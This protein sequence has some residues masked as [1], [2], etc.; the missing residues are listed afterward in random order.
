MNLDHEAVDAQIATMLRDCP[1]GT[2]TDL[3]EFA[4]AFLDRDGVRYASL[5]EDRTDRLDEEFALTD[6]ELLGLPLDA[7]RA[8][9]SPDTSM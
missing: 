2:T 3:T 5:D 1:R 6:Y 7:V 4:I 9:S 8:R